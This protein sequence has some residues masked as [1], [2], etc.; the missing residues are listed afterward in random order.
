MQVFLAF[1]LALAST[2]PFRLACYVLACEL[3]FGLIGGPI[4]YHRANSQQQHTSAMGED[5]ESEQSC[6][7]TIIQEG[8]GLLQ[9]LLDPSEAHADVL[10]DSAWIE[11]WYPGVKASELSLGNVAEFLSYTLFP[12]PAQCTRLVH[13]VSAHFVSALGLDIEVATCCEG[14]GACREGKVRAQ[15]AQCPQARFI[16]H[17]EESDP[18]KLSFRCM[19]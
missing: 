4:R 8:L 2:L 17:T 11:G 15:P 18:I 12:R 19:H 13:Q 7:P 14:E 3:G 16:S 10:R 1:I 6:P 5:D 9:Q